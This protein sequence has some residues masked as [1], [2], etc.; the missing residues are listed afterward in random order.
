MIL[1]SG[2]KT[3]VRVEYVKW[4]KSELKKVNDLDLEN[5]KWVENNNVLEIDK[6]TI[7]DFE[8]L[9]LANVDFIMGGAYNTNK[10]SEED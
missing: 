4:L 5:I 9:G 2:G 1:N 6:K 3:Y 10:E 8:F 7:E